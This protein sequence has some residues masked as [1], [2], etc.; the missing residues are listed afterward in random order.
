MCVGIETSVVW[1]HLVVISSTTVWQTNLTQ[2]NFN[3]RLWSLTA[4]TVLGWALWGCFTGWSAAAATAGSS[5]VACRR[6]LW[7]SWR[8][9]WGRW[10]RWS[11]CWGS[12]TAAGKRGGGWAQLELPHTHTHTYIHYKE[13][14]VPACVS[15]AADKAFMWCRPPLQRRRS[16]GVGGAAAS[17]WCT[18]GLLLHV[19]TTAVCLKHHRVH[20]VGK[21]K[22][23]ITL[24]NKQ[25]QC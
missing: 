3:T 9:G 20:H 7:W 24:K 14:G 1:C 22:K 16:R 10:G 15:S 11:D 25:M 8:W 4:H 5:C 12:L 18:H 23:L 17:F 21:E 13:V 19:V 2:G 6:R